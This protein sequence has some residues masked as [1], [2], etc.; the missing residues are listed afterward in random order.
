VYQSIF[1]TRATS[2]PSID[3]FHI[4]PAVCSR[5]G[6]GGPDG[7]ASRARC[8][9]TRTWVDRRTAMLLTL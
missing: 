2:I 4:R 5:W 1:G 8:W 7:S 6:R 9:S 3:L